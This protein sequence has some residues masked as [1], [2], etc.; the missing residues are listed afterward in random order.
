M[1]NKINV[2]NIALILGV[3]S[4]DI[5]CGIYDRIV[6]NSGVIKYVSEWV[7]GFYNA[8]INPAMSSPW[9]TSNVGL[10]STTASSGFNLISLVIIA[11]LG[12]ALMA[13]VIG[14]FSYSGGTE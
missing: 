13:G 8:A 3:S 2:K 12:I 5:S 6:N 9:E 7:A 4:L 14:S 1:T 10:V 11:M